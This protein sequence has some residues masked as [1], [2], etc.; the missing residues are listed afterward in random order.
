[1]HV[2]VGIRFDE[3]LDPLRLV[4]GEVV[5]DHVDLFVGGLTRDDLLQEGE[6]GLSAD[7]GQCFPR[8]S[9]VWVSRAA[10]NERVPWR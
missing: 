8:T 4:R 10:I 3:R 9:P 2:E 5:G 1:M 7:P 6:E